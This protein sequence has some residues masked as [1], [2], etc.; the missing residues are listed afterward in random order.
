VEEIGGAVLKEI[1][2][3]IARTTLYRHLNKLTEVKILI[4][5]ISLRTG[6]SKTGRE[7]ERAIIVYK[8]N[9]KEEGWI[10][11]L[12]KDLFDPYL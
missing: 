12:F 5:E 11:N 4:K 6:K 10:K 8:I 3:N 9:N 7:T 1:G 2:E